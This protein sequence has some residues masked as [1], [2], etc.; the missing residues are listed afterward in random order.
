LNRT[1]RTAHQLDEDRCAVI[2]C[3][4]A[5][6]PGN[7]RSQGWRRHDD[8]IGDDVLDDLSRLSRLH[9]APS[10]TFRGSVDREQDTLLLADAADIGLVNRRVYL[11]L[12]VG[13][14]C[15]RTAHYEINGLRRC[16]QT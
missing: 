2:I 5:V 1:P 11:H 14:D 6:R 9:D 13:E 7:R 4:L 16:P 8:I 10:K 15:G 12:A 3:T